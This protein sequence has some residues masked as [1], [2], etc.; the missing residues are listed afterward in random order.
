MKEQ[1]IA[2]TTDTNNGG[3]DGGLRDRLLRLRLR[4]GALGVRLGLGLGLRLRL[5]LLW[6]LRFVFEIHRVLFT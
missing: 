3:D 1:A 6:L 4:L 2:E 5:G